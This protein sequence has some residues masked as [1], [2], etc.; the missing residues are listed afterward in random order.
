MFSIGALVLIGLA[1]IFAPEIA[2]GD[3]MHINP[4]I[5][6]TAPSIG[7]PFGTDNLGRDMF[8][9]VLFGGRTSLLVGL[10]VTLA[11]MSV[12]IPLGL[13]S[14]YYRRVDVVLMRLVDGLMSFPGVVLA[15]AVAG[16]LGAVGPDGDDL[17]IR[18]A[19]RAVAAGGARA[20]ARR[21][22]TTDDRGGPRGRRP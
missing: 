4:A 17:A 12:A 5:R 6:F 13:L 8:K 15:T 14:G 10:V 1:T 3:P 20:G 2:G 9:I 16:Y 19:D 18:G 11:S 22:R 21:A 7:Q